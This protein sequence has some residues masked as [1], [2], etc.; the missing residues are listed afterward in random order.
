MTHFVVALHTEARP[1]IDHYGMQRVG[2]GAFPIFQGGGHRLVVT[3]IGKVAA[4]AAAAHLHETRLDVW[5][6]V[7][8]A[9]HRER[10][11]GELVRASRVQDGASGERYYPTIVDRTAVDTEGLTTVDVPE[12]AFATSDVFDMEASGFYPTALRFSTSELVHCVKIVSDNLETGIDLSSQRMGALVEDN[13]DAVTALVEQLEALA[14]DLDPLRTTPNLEPFLH[15]WHFT[16]S[17]RHRLT[18]LCRR[19]IA[20][21]RPPS[22]ED[23][24][25]SPTASA[26]LSQLTDELATLA[27]EQESF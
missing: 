23:F 24:S 8:V 17:Q 14:A 27:S 12:T 4:A 3:G 25:K 19:H 10:S 6:N 22:A 2:Q 13:L 7:G 26:V 15:S 21:G 18:R 1:L 16:A 5:L 11:R 9:G 20:F